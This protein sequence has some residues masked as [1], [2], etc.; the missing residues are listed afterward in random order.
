MCC[1]VLCCAVALWLVDQ[2]DSVPC[3]EVVFFDG[4]V[5]GCEHAR[6]CAPGGLLWLVV[7]EGEA[8]LDVWAAARMCVWSCVVAVRVRSSVGAV[9]VI[10]CCGSVYDP[11]LGLC[12][13]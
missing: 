6:A 3:S 10:L 1:A 2:P 9:C 8:I 5:C 7:E 13:V 4:V 12:V 11:V